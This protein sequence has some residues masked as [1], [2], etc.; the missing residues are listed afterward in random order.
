MDQ[1]SVL[2]VSEDPEFART[3]MSRWQAERTLPGFVVMA[4]EPA[5]TPVAAFDLAIVGP[6]TAQRL[7]AVLAGL[8]FVGRPV[9]HVFNN[10]TEIAQPR[11]RF[12]QVVWLRQHEEWPGTTVVVAREMLRAALTSE[13]ARRAEQH[14]S[15]HQRDAAVGQYVSDMRHGFNNALTSVLGNAELIL[16]DETA[17]TPAVRDKIKTIQTMALRMHEM[18]Q[19]LTSLESEFRL[20]EREGKRE[21]RAVRAGTH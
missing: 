3:L 13:R 20:A 8:T 6:T 9:L 4:G 5:H 21:P 12:P 18:M 15:A 19:R 7:E 11:L 14:A 2:L 17:V 16:L 10:E 1:P